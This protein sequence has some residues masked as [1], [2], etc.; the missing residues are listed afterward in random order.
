MK[1]SGKKD[2]NNRKKNMIYIISLGV[3]FLVQV[4]IFIILLQVYSQV[5]CF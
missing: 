5:E 1:E 4:C 3:L 2:E